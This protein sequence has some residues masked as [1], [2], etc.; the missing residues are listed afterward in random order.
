M[1]ME[2]DAVYIVSGIID[3]RSRDVRT[4]VQ[5]TFRIVE[6]NFDNGWYCFVLRLR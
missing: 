4:A 2:P 3:T 1:F 5:D 6:E